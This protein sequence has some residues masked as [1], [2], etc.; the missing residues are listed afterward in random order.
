MITIR[1]FFPFVVAVFAA[2]FAPPLLMAVPT[3]IA[4]ES[5][6]GTGIGFTTSVPQFDEP[7]VRDERFLLGAAQ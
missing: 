2:V 6:E 4:R 1:S 5:F 3:E 7:T